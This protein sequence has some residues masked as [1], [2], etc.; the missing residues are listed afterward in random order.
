MKKVFASLLF[1]FAINV[2]AQEK[3][4]TI[5]EVKGW[6][7]AEGRIIPTGKIIYQ[8][9]EVLPVAEALAED[10]KVMFGK[11]L[12]IEKGKPRPGDIHL[13][14]EDLRALGEE[15]YQLDIDNIIVIK[16][17]NLKGL[18]WGT[19][20]ML[21]ICDNNAAHTLPKGHLTDRPEYSHRGF[22]IDCGRKYI[23]MS[24]LRNLVKIMGYYKMNVLQ[25]HLN[26]NGLTIGTRLRRHSDLSVLLSQA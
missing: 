12:T 24:Y 18:Y 20:T 3:P 9:K 2:I 25:I 14:I 19:R 4:F 10:Y 13:V 21:Q 17:G 6:K 16:S 8:D 22:M 5:P 7:A 11:Q 15:G 23:P 1:L 26:D